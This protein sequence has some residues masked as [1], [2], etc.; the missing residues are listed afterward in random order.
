MRFAKLF[1]LIIALALALILGGCA[2]SDQIGVQKDVEVPI[3]ITVT[4]NSGPV[5]ISPATD[6]NVI[7]G[8]TD[9]ESAAAAEASPDITLPIAQQGGVAS[10]DSQVEGV[11]AEQDNS[12]RDSANDNSTTEV[13]KPVPVL[14][15]DKEKVEVLDNDNSTSELVRVE[16]YQTEYVKDN[17]KPFV[18]LNAPGVTGQILFELPGCADF[19]VPDGAV[20]FSPGGHGQAT[21]F[22]GSDTPEGVKMDGRSS[23]FMAPG[24]ENGEL[25]VTYER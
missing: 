25:T 23:V 24:C 16:T 14:K 9:Q 20:K 4:N 1:V 21:Y 13:V 12:L 7:A 6:W 18:W 10:A 2:S 8:N 3:S 5:Y 22:Q 19:V 11:E 15:P 17:P